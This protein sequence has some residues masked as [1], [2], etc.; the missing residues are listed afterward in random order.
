MDAYVGLPPTISEPMY[1]EEGFGVGFR[2]SH[3]P[4]V[5]CA[6]HPTSKRCSCGRMDIGIVPSLSGTT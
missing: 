6:Y 5:E 1:N 4:G 2:I 3:P